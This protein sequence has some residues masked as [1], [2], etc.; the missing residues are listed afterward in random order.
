MGGDSNHFST[1]EAASALGWWLEAGVDAAVQEAPRDWLKPTPAPVAAVAEAIAPPVRDAEP[2]PDTL[3]LFR[4]WLTSSAALPLAGAGA[5]RIL[6]HGAEG[7]PLMLIAEMP[8]PDDAAA[9]R[10]IGGEAWALVTRM[11][12]AIGIAADDAYCASLACFHAPGAKLGASE[13]AECAEIA[14][15]HI[16]LARPQR[17]LLLGDAPARALLGKP[18]PAAR[19]HATKVEGV[20]TVVTF[21]P[22]FLMQQP[23]NKALAW[24]DLL[25]LMEDE[26]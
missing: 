2:L 1:A 10:P 5:K 6:P 13:L 21:H 26:A 24:R 7:A 11:L 4:D 14:R 20:R 16:A 15:R 19:G 23:S 12:A 8:G 17:L 18:L 9:G 3:D 25:L 22:R